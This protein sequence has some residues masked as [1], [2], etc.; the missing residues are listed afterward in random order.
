MIALGLD[1]PGPVSL[2]LDDWSGENEEITLAE[3]LDRSRGLAA[4][5]DA[6]KVAQ[7][8][9]RQWVVLARRDAGREILFVFAM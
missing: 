8:V 7:V 1:T 6:V 2:W 3:G 9:P 4:A 5:P